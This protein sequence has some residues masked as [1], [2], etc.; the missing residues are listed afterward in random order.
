MRASAFILALAWQETPATAG[1]EVAQGAE[2]DKA[3][4]TLLEGME[5]AKE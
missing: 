3:I 4:D 5:K 1:A 2:M